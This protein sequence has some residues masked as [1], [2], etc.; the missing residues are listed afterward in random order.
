MVVSMSRVYAIIAISSYDDRL[1]FVNNV[2]L[3]RFYDYCDA[4]RFPMSFTIRFT[5]LFH[6][7]VISLTIF[8]SFIKMDYYGQCNVNKRTDFLT[9]NLKCNVMWFSF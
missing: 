9:I 1:T 2:I 8:Y 6:Y 4:F 3:K 7:Y 5:F